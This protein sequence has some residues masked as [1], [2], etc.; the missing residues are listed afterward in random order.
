MIITHDIVYLNHMKE[1]LEYYL[2]EGL[3]MGKMGCDI[4]FKG[5]REEGAIGLPNSHQMVWV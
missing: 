5:R 1:S 3:L 2:F 4:L